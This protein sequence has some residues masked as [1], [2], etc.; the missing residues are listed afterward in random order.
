MSAC[1]KT[2]LAGPMMSEVLVYFLTLWLEMLFFGI[3]KGA[4]IQDDLP[5][6][7]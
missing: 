4:G 6:E 1:D 7:L 2:C 5:H 3:G